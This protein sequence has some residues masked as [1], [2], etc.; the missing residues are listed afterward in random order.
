VKKTLAIL[1][2]VVVSAVPSHAAYFEFIWQDPAHPQI[3]GGSLFTPKMEYDGIGTDVA[4]MFHAADPNDTIIPQKL[5]DLGIKPISWCALCVGG[6]G[7]SKT[8]FATI[9][10][11]INVAPTLLGPVAKAVR[12]SKSPAAQIAADL[13]ASGD[14]QSGLKI[15]VAWKSDVIVNGTVQPFDKWHFSP[16]FVFGETWRFGPK[17]AQARMAARRR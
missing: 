7:N 2:L 15:G 4:M 9:S 3:S 11:S 17:A 14:G 16:R 10:A 5:Q 8:G 1:A 13:I 6:G 12:Q